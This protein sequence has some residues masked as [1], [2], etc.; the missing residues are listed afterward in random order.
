MKNITT[1]HTNQ[2]EPR[3]IFLGSLRVRVVR[4]KKNKGYYVIYAV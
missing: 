4:G 3:D 2:C 1:N